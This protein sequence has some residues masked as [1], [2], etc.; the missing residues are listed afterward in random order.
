MIELNKSMKDK[1]PDPDAVWT[2]GM[3]CVA[4]SSNDKRWYRAV[5]GDS[6]DD[7]LKV[8]IK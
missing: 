2:V 6:V 3:E 7:K 5:V 1:S 4:R 8:S